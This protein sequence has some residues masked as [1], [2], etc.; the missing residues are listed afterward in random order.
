MLK[1]LY[2]F[3]NPRFQTLHADYKVDFRPRFGHGQPPHPQLNSIIE[4]QQETYLTWLHRIAEEKEFPHSLKDAANESNPEIP[5]WNNGFLPGLD[6]LALYAF[7]KHLKP[8]RYV[9]VGSGN[10]T[11]VAYQAI[12]KYSPATEL[13]SIDPYPRAEIDNLAGKVVREPYESTNYPFYELLEPGDI[14]FID[15]SH[16][17]LPNSDATTFFLEDFP[18]L[19]PGVIVQIHDIYLPD[20]YPQVMCDRFYSE[21]YGLAMYLLANPKRFKPIFPSW[22][23][24][25]QQELA[26][27]L[28]PLW[29]SLDVQNVERHGG[30]FWLEI[31]KNT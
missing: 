30:S 22:Y 12:K 20:D 2:R 4:A 24:S 17:I 9:E 29:E 19:K 3:F 13:I 11:K 5:A 21:Q 23:I 7:I 26:S 8:K 16:R 18:Q 28:N 6:I 27:K 1:S 14:F 10:S 31:G 25:Q 15:N